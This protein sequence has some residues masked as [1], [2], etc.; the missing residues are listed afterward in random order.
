[1]TRRSLCSLVL[2]AGFLGALIATGAPAQTPKRGGILNSML[3]EDTRRASPSTSRP[4][5]PTCGRCRRATR[6]S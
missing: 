3:I 4:P 6:T 2:A 1:M 5:S